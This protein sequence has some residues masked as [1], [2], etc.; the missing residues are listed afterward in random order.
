MGFSLV[1]GIFSLLIGLVARQS[2]PVYGVLLGTGITL[3]GL[4][5]VGIYF[6]RTVMKDDRVM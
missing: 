2:A 6:A 5:A 3:V 1:T 4:I